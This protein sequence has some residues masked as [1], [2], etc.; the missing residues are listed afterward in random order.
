MAAGQA[1]WQGFCVLGNNDISCHALW[2]FLLHSLRC[3][4]G[5]QP[6]GVNLVSQTFSATAGAPGCLQGAKVT[7]G[8][9]S[10]PLSLME[11]HEHDCHFSG[12]LGDPLPHSG[13][14]SGQ[15]HKQLE[16]SKK[17]LESLPSVTSARP[18][19]QSVLC[20]SPGKQ[21]QAPSH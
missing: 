9:A 4:H 17:A 10:I 7:L 18:V 1:G 15:W 2:S 11:R 12:S 19:T 20:S 5:Q 13:L 16:E 8:K 6:L 21:G 14:P 3:S